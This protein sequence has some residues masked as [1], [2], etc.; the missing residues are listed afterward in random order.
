MTQEEDFSAGC[1]RVPAILIPDDDLTL[2]R[3]LATTL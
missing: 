1:W 2:A 3:L